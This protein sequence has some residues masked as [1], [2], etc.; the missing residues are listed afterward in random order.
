MPNDDAQIDATFE[1][2]EGPQ[3]NATYDISE[4]PINATFAIYA[5]GT[6][7]GSIDGDI[8]NQTDLQ[9]ALDSKQDIIEDLTSIR[10]GATLGSTA[11]QPGDN[12]TDL[13]NNA[14]YISGIDSNDVTTALGYTPVN[15]SSLSIVAVTGNYTD[16]SNKP[17]I[18][19]GN[20]TITVNNTSVGTITANQTSNNSITISVPTTASEIGALPSTTTINDL[21]SEAQQ[22]ALNSG[23]TSTIVEQVGTNAY[24][25]SNLQANKQ[26]NL[27]AGANIQINGNTISAT[28]TTYSAGDNVTIT[29]GTISATDTTYSAGAN[30]TI[31]NG[32]ISAASTSYIAGNGINISNGTISVGTTI[33]S[34]TDIKDGATT[35][36]VNSTSV[37]TITANQ[38]DAQAITINVPTTATEVGAL[39]STTTIND[40]TSTAQQDA[41]NSGVTSTIVSQV[42]TNAST[43]STI[44]SYIPSGTSALNPLTNENYVNNAIS[45]NTANFIGTFDSVAEL[46]AY[47]GTLTNN[48]YAFV[49]TTDSAGNTLYDRYKWNGT[50]WL[51]EYEINN[52]SF[53]SDQWAAINS[54]IT[55]V[56]VTQIASNTSAI[57]ANT[58]AISGKQ[59]TLTAGTNITISG[60]TISAASTSYAAGTNIQINGNTISATDT[61]YIAG[62]NITIENGTI[63]ATATTYSAGNGIDITGGTISTDT[64]IASKTDIGSADL[65]IQR[66]GS[67][68][69]TFSANATSGVTVN[70]SVPTTATDVGAL[71]SSTIIGDGRVIFQKNGTAISTITANQTSTTTVNFTI[72]TT[73]SDVNALP[74]TTTIGAANTTIQVNSTA[75][76][77]INAN[78]TSA[79]AINISVPTNTNQL[80]NGAGFI[81]SSD[82]SSYQL[83][84]QPV[85]DLG[86]TSGTIS[87]SDN[88]L[89]KLTANGNITFSLPSISDYSK[90]HQIFVQFV[91]STVRTVSVGT[92]YYFGDAA[93]DLSSTG[94]YNFYWEYNNIFHGW[95]MGCLHVGATS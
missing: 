81:T 38:T 26:D 86:S 15:P 91:M 85:T 31:T 21:T 76:G 37:G 93:P 33:A 57:A 4:D 71:P 41:L 72:P 25:I 79:S 92:T 63:S 13:E 55:D 88:T 23:V 17:T 29:N 50:E 61:T 1:I 16:L 66:N 32:T 84:A 46:E 78:A 19:N 95:V 27:N 36:L 67:G 2:S 90:L 53:T 43:I 9:N 35:I 64:T 20:T 47:S 65:T 45:A 11:I 70:I 3:L 52:S 58:L 94:Y 54:G 40:L 10:E 87:L 30:I 49:A 28:N 6:T 5:A 39:P 83:K 82:L 80:T 8:Q 51:F 60:N 7:W 75:V 18:G 62:D 68:I 22:S 56:S 77:T 89:Y 42:G 44:N 34:K 14:G 12:I 24:D 48:D 73:A 59:D 69:G 74:D